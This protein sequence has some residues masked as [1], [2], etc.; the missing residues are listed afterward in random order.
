LDHLGVEVDTTTAVTAAAHVSPTPE[1]TT[2]KEADITCCYA[3]GQDLGA[4]PRPGSPSGRSSRRSRPEISCFSDSVPPA[5]A[6]PSARIQCVWS[7]LSSHSRRV[8]RWRCG[9]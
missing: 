8:P 1:L 7:Y 4:R 3:S 9:S 6:R 5:L 2:T